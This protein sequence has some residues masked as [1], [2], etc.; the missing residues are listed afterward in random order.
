MWSLD[1]G[2][3]SVVQNAWSR[4]VF[5]TLVYKVVTK[6]KQ[7]KQPLRALNRN[8]FSNIEKAVGVARKAKI[9]SSNG[10]E[11]TR[12]FHNLIRYRQIHNRVMSI[13]G[14]DGI[15]YHD[16]QEIETAFLTYYQ[17][18]LG[19]RQR[20]TP[21]HIPTMRCGKLVT[22]NHKCLLLASVIAEGIKECIFSILLSLLVMMASQNPTSVLEFRPI[23]CCN[24]IYKCL[25][26]VICN[27]VSKI[28]PD[29]IKERQGGFVKGRNIVDN[30]LICQDLVRLYNRRAASPRCLVKTDLKKAYD[31]V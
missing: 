8:K 16:P 29:I 2:I 21:L 7:L 4:P 12:F 25:S 30:V 1:D 9:D 27:R 20:T 10:N 3:T 13:R 28:M 22:E 17:S 6:L 15:L 23:A 18:L 19:T 24:T 5:G 14:Q 31:S 26:K 11:N